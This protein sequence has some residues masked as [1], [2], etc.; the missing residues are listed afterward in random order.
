MEDV[1]KIVKKYS[2]IMN[3][4]E[5][6]IW[7][8]P[9]VGY[10]E[11]KTNDYMLTAFS[12][13]GY[14]VE[15]PKDITGFTAYYDTGRT[16]P[17]VLV[18]A[19]LDS[20]LCSQHPEC[21]KQ[22]GAVHN[23]GHHIQ[24]ASI[25]GVAGAIKEKSINEE[26]CGKIKFCIVPAEEGI[27]VGYRNS[28]VEQGV[29]N[30]TSGKPEFISRG[31]LDDVDLAFMVHTTNG[32]EYDGTTYHF[33][34]GSNGVIRKKTVVMG[35]AAHAGGAPWDGVNALYA[36]ELCFSACNALRETFKDDD[37]IRF[38]SII[39]KGG[40]AVN[41]IPEEIVFESYVRAAN[42]KALTQANYKI[43]R[44]I[45][46]A[47]LAIGASVEIK[48]I[49]GSEP[50]FGSPEF[51]KLMREVGKQLAGEEK[52]KSYNVWL[53]SSTDM[54]DVSSLVPSVHAYVDAS[55]GN[56]H[57]K[58]FALKNPTKTCIDSASL[59]V[60]TLVE[61]LKDG[62]KK[63]YEIKKAYTPTYESVEKYL[64]QKRNISKSQN[65]IEYQG[66]NININLK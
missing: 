21:D 45:V 53:T 11:F 19:E 24:C 23:C 60:A 28:L 4:A 46:G 42:T 10:K 14:N 51:T 9:E 3:K 32:D 55:T 17:T 39:T 56:E 43:N 6:Y 18:L 50:L 40:D 12:E 5:R 37:Y 2:E 41:A 13:L 8:N 20:L 29:I 57:G 64:Q 35:K 61:L 66:G 49:A 47:C 22:T 36:T 7:R 25:L 15:R 54:G 33:D 65:C 30:F 62:G 52:C 1:K 16:G 44:A 38:H 59:Q 58:D 31:M 63:A 48:D 34:L 26:L 27:E